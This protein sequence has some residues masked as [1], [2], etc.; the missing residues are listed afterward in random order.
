MPRLFP[1]DWSKRLLS[2]DF[3]AVVQKA[4]KKFSLSRFFF[5]FNFFLS[6]FLFNI[7]ASPLGEYYLLFTF[8]RQLSCQLP[9][10]THWR[11]S[12]LVR[13]RP[14]ELPSAGRFMFILGPRTLAAAL[15]IVSITWYVLRSS[16]PH[17]MLPHL[18]LGVAGF[19]SL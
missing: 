8:V 15:L 7:C 19:E 13:I 1:V 18:L 11:L 16:S 4:F 3:L 2:E 9:I 5:Y 14:P 17:G 12:P 6:S 10:D